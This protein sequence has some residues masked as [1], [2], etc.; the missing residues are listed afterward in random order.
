VKTLFLRAAR[1]LG[2]DTF[3]LADV[4]AVLSCDAIPLVQDQV[5]RQAANSLLRAKDLESVDKA[6]RTYRL[7]VEVPDIDDDIT[8]RVKV[9]WETHFA[10][11]SDL[12]SIEM[13]SRVL[14]LLLYPFD[15]SRS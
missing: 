7:L 12:L 8:R 4:R 3:T 15:E 9:C 5:L 2:T 13:L 11:V 10:P 14:A 6:S 1:E